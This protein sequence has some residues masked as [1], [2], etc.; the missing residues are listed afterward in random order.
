MQGEAG[1]T[2]V[3][4]VPFLEL[5][6]LR[7]C[8]HMALVLLL[9]AEV[10][11][12]EFRNGQELYY[13]NGMTSIIII[14]KKTFCSFALDIDEC[15]VLPNLCKNGQCINTIGSFRCHCNLGY[16]TDITGTTCVGKICYYYWK[17]N[18]IWTLDSYN[19]IA[20]Y[21]ILLYLR[22][23]AFWIFLNYFIFRS[24]WMFSVS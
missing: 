11:A 20:K 10:K 6:H 14:K 24:G 3:N 9:M 18:H 19:Q 2:S 16:T 8:V 15:R 4:S 12:E 13:G 1:V 21:T 5:D 23:I 17:Q 7:R 22:Y